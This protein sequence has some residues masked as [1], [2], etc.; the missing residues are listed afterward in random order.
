MVAISGKL[1]KITANL[2]ATLFTFAMEV[3][4]H[5]FRKE[6]MN[7]IITLIPKNKISRTAFSSIHR[8]I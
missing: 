7:E 6:A 8:H 1:V 3:A 5:I 2:Q 4:G